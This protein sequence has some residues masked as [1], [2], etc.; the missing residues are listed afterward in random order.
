MGPLQPRDR[1]VVEAR[2]EGHQEMEVVQISQTLGH[3]NE[4]LYDL[5]AS[6]ELVFPYDNRRNP[7]RYA[8][9]LV[10]H[11]Q[12]IRREILGACACPRLIEKLHG[13]HL[14]VDFE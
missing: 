8:I 5:N 4:L 6:A 2:D 1:R 10:N 3:V 11:R 9:K 7:A 13:L 14:Y 12:D